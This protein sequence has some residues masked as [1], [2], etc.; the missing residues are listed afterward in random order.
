[1]PV[2]ESDRIIN[3][4]TADLGL[5]TASARGSRRTKGAQLLSTQV[6]SLS[7]FDL[8]HNKG[9]FSVNAADLAEP[10]LALHQDMDRLVCAAHMAEVL[11]DA[12]R[13]DVAQP[14]LYRLWAFALQ[15]LQQTPD[16][17]LCVHITQL[18]LLSEI[19]FAPRLDHC[20]ICGNPVITESDLKAPSDLAALSLSFSVQS[21]GVVCSKPACRRAASDARPISGGARSCLKY[22]VEAPLPRLYQCQADPD[23][24]REF[25]TISER[26]LSQQ[27]EKSYTKLKML[28]SLSDMAIQAPPVSGD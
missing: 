5:V 7:D 18:R 6:Y 24:R 3:I 21:C 4:L 11:I 16:P 14:E 27:M 9:H 12:C 13:D 22:C 26:Y 10:F 25:C 1:V 19:G 23:I 20:I 8:F 15:A 28:E 2:G 17:L